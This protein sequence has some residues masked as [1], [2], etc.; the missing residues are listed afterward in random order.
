MTKTIEYRL[1]VIRLTMPRVRGV[2]QGTSMSTYIT[3]SWYWYDLILR[4]E[5]QLAA[6]VWLITW[7]KQKNSIWFQF[8]LFWFS[9]ATGGNRYEV[10]NRLGDIQI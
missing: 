2:G 9:L 4:K 1:T 3:E 10:T 5:V 8:Y 7:I 6:E